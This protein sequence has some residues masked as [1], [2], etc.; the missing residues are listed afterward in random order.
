MRIPPENILY[1]ICI[2]IYHQAHHIS[3]HYFLIIKTNVV[4]DYDLLNIFARSFVSGLVQTFYR[5]MSERG[6]EN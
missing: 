4:S 6:A 2:Y 5:Y 1:G 3:D